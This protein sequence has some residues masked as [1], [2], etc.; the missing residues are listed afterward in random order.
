[1]RYPLI[2][3]PHVGDVIFSELFS[4]LIYF[5]AIWLQQLP[6]WIRDDHIESGSTCWT[7]AEGVT[8]DEFAFYF[9]SILSQFVKPLPSYVEAEISDIPELETPRAPW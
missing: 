8:Y 6:R 7:V 9:K 2:I 5:A 3:E 4:E 1:M